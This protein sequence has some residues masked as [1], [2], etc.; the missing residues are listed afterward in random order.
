MRALQILRT[1]WR[2][3]PWAGGPWSGR[4]VRRSVRRSVPSGRSMRAVRSVRAVVLLVAVGGGLLW[5]WAVLRLAVHPEAAGPWETA[6]AAGGWSLG[7]IPLHAVPGSR[8][9]SRPGRAKRRG[10][11][12]VPASPEA[13]AE[14]VRVGPV[15]R[16]S[17]DVGYRGCVLPGH[18]HGDHTAEV[19]EPSG[20]EAGEAGEADGPGSS[21]GSIVQG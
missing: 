18:G 11:A 9:V 12:A 15:G 6:M 20:G 14:F 16:L 8:A 2:P 10:A 3:D 17:P 4:A 5:W 21:G 13:P 1:A 7:L 19:G